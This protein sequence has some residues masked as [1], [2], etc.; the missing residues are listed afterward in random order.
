MTTLTLPTVNQEKV[1]SV[2]SEE[3]LFPIRHT[4]V[5]NEDTP[6][7]ERVPLLIVRDLLRLGWRIKSNSNK[8]LELMP[9]R[10]YEKNVVKAAMAYSRNEIIDRNSLWIREHENLAR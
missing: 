10:D 5:I 7:E 4:P 2:A 3:P 6:L 9:P 1:S 8:S